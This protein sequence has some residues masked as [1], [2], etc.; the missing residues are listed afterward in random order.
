MY[1]SSR[2]GLV[3]IYIFI[4]VCVYIHTCTHALYWVSQKVIQ[5]LRRNCSLY[6]WS[7]KN[8]GF[9]MNHSLDNE[10]M[11][12][13]TLLL[14]SLTHNLLSYHI[15]LIFS[16]PFPWIFMWLSSSSQIRFLLMTIFL[17]GL[18]YSNKINILWLVP[19][20]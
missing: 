7:L 8:A 10:M 11:K 16:L 13:Q 15:I 3:F 12:T 20:P 1:T 18:I 2:I 9:P 6:L 17:I 4:C 14:P 5:S 19:T